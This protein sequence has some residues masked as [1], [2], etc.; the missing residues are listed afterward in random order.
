M[1]RFRVGILLGNKE[2]DYLHS[3]RIGVQNVLEESGD[4]LINIADLIPYHTSASTEIYLRVAFKLAGRLNL[5]A[6]VVPLGSTANYMS[7]GYPVAAELLTSMDPEKTLVLERSVPGYRCLTKDNAPGMHACMR[8]LIEE[9]GYRR[10][11]FVSGPASS[12]GARERERIYYE[13]MAAHGIEV[14]Q[15]MFVRGEFSGDCRES[16]EQLMDQNPNLEAI[17]CASDLIAQTTY[18][19]LHDRNLT[20]GRDIAV[21]G[22]DDQ[23]RA[24]HMDPPLTTV[25]MTGYDFGCMAGR[26]ALRLCRNLDQKE[27]G[28]T[29]SL[30]V[31]ESCGENASGIIMQYQDL[32][33]RDPFPLDEIVDL[34]TDSSLILARNSV[35]R[36]FRGHMRTLVIE[37]Q[38]TY[39]EHRAHPDRHLALFES[40]A[41]SDLFSNF[42]SGQISLEGFHRVAVSLMEALI[43]ENPDDSAWILK[44]ISY[45]HLRV[46]RLL[47]HEVYKNTQTMSK[48]EWTTFHISEDAL[49]DD[50]HPRTT[51]ELM[52]KELQR[53]GVRQADLFL[54]PESVSSIGGMALAFS[55]TVTCVGSLNNDRVRVA[56]EPINVELQE[57]MD[58]VLPRYGAANVCTVGS[59]MAGDEL[60][61]ILTMDPGN[62]GD[63]DQLMILLNVG[64]ACKHLQMLASERDMNE[65][66]SKHSLILERQ[67]QRDEMTKLYNR[68][69][70]NNAVACELHDRPHSLYA[71]LYLDLDGLKDINDN[72]GHDVGDEAICN[73]AR[74]L[75]HSLPSDCVIARMGGDEFVVFSRI[76]SEADASKLVR[77]IKEGMNVF[78]KHGNASYKLSASCGIHCFLP[79]D[80]TNEALHEAML[81]AD[82]R[83][84]E[85]KRH[86][87]S[88]RRFQRLESA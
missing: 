36:K 66:L 8:H 61:G 45:L 52:F 19:V 68:R 51:Y 76:N 48:R 55:D 22:Y 44:Q 25:R 43:A 77:N 46:A 12:T 47:N 41:L 37:V 64:L 5:D 75:T 33:S 85:D 6:V 32:L 16:I 18:Q 30:V 69:G 71:L 70:L 42:Q 53:L 34:L 63:N 82:S 17:V 54:L 67:S 84:Y 56:R 60:L 86:H 39:E 59:V 72:H 40:Q 24:S 13:E 28:V 73:T 62:L 31:R 14:S 49:V 65:I 21:T 15:S 11:G 29:S 2:D 9:H 83:M 26:E 4:I 50:F 20:V 57:L 23:P 80:D 7:G 81:K 10:I 38:R 87:K 74:I 27:M 78:N 88:S 1:R 79:E 35:R 58:F 3:I